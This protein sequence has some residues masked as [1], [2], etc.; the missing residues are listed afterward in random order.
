MPYCVQIVY[1]NSCWEA[2]S[3][4]YLITAGSLMVLLGHHQTLI[5]CDYTRDSPSQLNCSCFKF[6]CQYLPCILSKAVLL[7]CHKI[8][9]FIFIFA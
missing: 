9:I 1:F 6:K 5:S 8:R 2:E 3:L 4:A 7:V